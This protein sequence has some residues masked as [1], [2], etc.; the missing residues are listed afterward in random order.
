M[1]RSVRIALV[2]L[3]AAVPVARAQGSLSSQ[4]FGYPPGQLS[5]QASGMGGGIAE[6]DP[7]ST[8]NPA[9]LWSWGRS[10][11]YFQFD[12]EF[13]RV[14]AEGADE[15]STIS[16]FPLVA[17][18]FHVGQ[19]AVIGVSSSTFLDRTWATTFESGTRIG[20]DSVTFTQSSRVN[21]AIN[22]IRLA[23]SWRFGERVSVGAALHRLA[24]ENRMAISRVFPDTQQF[25]TISENFTLSYTGAAYSAGAIWR[26]TPQIGIGASARVGGDI[27]ASRGDTVISTG[28]VPARFGFGVRLDAVP[29]AVFALRA[30]HVSWTDMNELGSASLRE[31]DGWDIGGGAEL[32]GPRL[33]SAPTVVRAGFR[34]RV[35]PFA[36][37]ETGQVNETAYSAGVGLPLAAGRATLDMSLQR[38]AR[39]SDAGARERSWILSFGVGVRP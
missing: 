3:V 7:V 13:R 9:A 26:V 14:Q 6:L 35:L 19:R 39:D 25:G 8:I 28:S 4:G 16:R 30:E 21:G 38:A 36:I 1:I 5:T 31:F 2:A 12:P 18:A 20:A 17:A 34:R 29:G 15:R 37:E 27:E 11:L 10:G 22:D 33:F 23:G 24:G 32:S